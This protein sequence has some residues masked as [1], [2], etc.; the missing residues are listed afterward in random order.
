M[1]PIRACLLL[2]LAA[3]GVA[4]AQTA[5]PAAAPAPKDD[6]SLTWNGITLYGIVDVGVQ[7]ITHGVPISDYFPAGSY[8]GPAKGNNASVTGITPSNLSQSRIG[9]SGF[10]PIPSVGDLAF[11]FRMET[12][13]NPQSGNLSD[14]LKSLTLN[15]GKTLSQ[16]SVGVDTSVAGQAFAGALY[17]GLSSPT[18][19][20]LTFGRHTTLVADGISKYDPMG[21]AQAFSIIGLSGFAAGGGNT[22]D[23][24]LDQSVKY[25]AKFGPV[26]V[27]ALY[28]FNGSNGGANTGVQGQLGLDFLGT[29]SVD[30][31][32]FK[33]KDAIGVS[34]LSSAQVD[35]LPVGFSVSNSLSGTISDTTSYD[36]MASY[37][38]GP[39]KLFAG[40]ERIKFD[41]PS[42]PLPVGFVTIGGYVLAYVNNTAYDNEKVEKVFWGGAKWTTPVQ[43][44]EL[45]AAY[46]GYKQDA[47][48]GGANEGCS[49]SVSGACSGNLKAVSLLADYRF[50]KRFD[51]Y[52]G[53]MWSGVDGGLAN[54]YLNTNTTA[55][56]TGLRF[57]F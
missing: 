14:G 41:N 20:T 38:L 48:A 16:Q 21:A 50:T 7:Y 18:Y 42:T 17:A 25:T 5:A 43:G 10:E 37:G 11:V 12:F 57:K 56:T 35:T 9:L 54:G 24:R 22:E 46:Y 55:I 36:L 13:F 26:H 49:T 33:M 28:K 53:G 40:Y 27:G 19:G 29:G 2:S 32:Y 3:A 51:A 8:P 52:L 47:Y 15:N 30:A 4:Q 23:R 34:S 44:L 45:T 6:S 1:K 31:Y 39:V